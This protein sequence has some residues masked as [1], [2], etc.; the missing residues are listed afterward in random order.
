MAENIDH[1]DHYGGKD[2]TYEVIKVLK[3]WLTQEE[4]QGFCKGNAIK[5]SARAG[6]KDGQPASRD[7][8]KAQWYLAEMLEGFK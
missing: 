7:L 3:A 5:Y 1:P 8:Q 2:N 4:F 6:K